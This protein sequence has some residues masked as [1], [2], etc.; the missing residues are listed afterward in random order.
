MEW[1]EEPGGRGADSVPRTVQSGTE[2]AVQ[3][4]RGQGV[5]ER[6]ELL[7]LPVAFLPSQELR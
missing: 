6:R 3:E 4:K 1:R 2:H 7:A 5:A